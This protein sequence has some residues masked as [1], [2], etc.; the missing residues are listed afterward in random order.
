MS[1]FKSK[2]SV[3]EVKET[4]SSNFISKSGMYDVIIKNAWVEKSDKSESTVINLRIEHKGT[5]Q[6]LYNAFRLTNGDGKDNERGH[7]KLNKLLIILG[8]DGLSDPET[9]NIPVGKKS[10]MVEKEVL[11]ELE[12]QEVTLELINS[13]SKYNGKIYK[14]LDIRDSFRTSDKASAPEI[15]NAELSD[16][17]KEK[18]GT[19]YNKE[20]SNGITDSLGKDV[21]REEADQYDKEQQ[22]SSSTSETTSDKKSDDIF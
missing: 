18:I 7:D 20:V 21:T 5:L 22:G 14:S 11:T 9:M 17:N 15:V 6:T 13:Y 10:A 2:K 1:F 4:G 12:D 3:E 19:R 16:E 8:I